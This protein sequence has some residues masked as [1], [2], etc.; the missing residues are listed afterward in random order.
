MSRVQNYQEKLHWPLY[1]SILFKYPITEKELS[2]PLP[3][4]FFTDIQ[5]KTKL[6]TNMDQASVLP[7]TNTYEVRSLRLIVAPGFGTVPESNFLVNEPDPFTEETGKEEKAGAY[8]KGGYN[9]YY[10][11]CA[12]DQLDTMMRQLMSSLVYSSVLSLIVGEKTMLQAPSFLFPSG[13]GV[14]P[15][16]SHGEPTP[17]ATFRLA[18]P[19]IIDRQQNFR[20]ELNLPYGWPKAWTDALNWSGGCGFRTD[21]RIWVILDGYLTRD[22]Q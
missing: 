20:V 16:A 19:V 21:I 13:A 18:E 5:G 4:R 15:M 7:S 14:F 10:K 2:N 3:K 12:I 9:S 17:V 8:Q 6:D 22:V 1:D 11:S